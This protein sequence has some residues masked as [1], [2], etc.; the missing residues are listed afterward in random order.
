VEPWLNANPHIYGI[1]LTHCRERSAVD[2][3]PFFIDYAPD[4]RWKKYDR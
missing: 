3:H 4:D 2:D 1:W